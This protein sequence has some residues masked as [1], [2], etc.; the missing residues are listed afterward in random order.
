MGLSPNVRLVFKKIPN[1]VECLPEP[2]V[3]VVVNTVFRV[4][5]PKNY[6]ASGGVSHR[7]P[8]C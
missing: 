2:I 7:N 4:K 5:I 1:V 8:R 6:A 3:V